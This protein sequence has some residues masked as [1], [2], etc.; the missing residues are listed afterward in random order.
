M[1]TIRKA[2]ALLT[3]LAIAGTIACFQGFLNLRDASRLAAG[4][5]PGAYDLIRILL[6]FEV[7]VVFLT[8]SFNFGFF[9][10]KKI[11]G[12]QDA[13][14]F[15]SGSSEYL[16]LQQAVGA[17]FIFVV[18]GY[19]VFGPGEFSLGAVTALSTAA[20]GLYRVLKSKLD[21]SYQKPKLSLTKR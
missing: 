12:D 20:W 14:S 7:V 13:E 18:R 15:R 3:I 6:F 5:D 1:K 21:G 16:I 9:I 11:V 8:A 10:I 2:A 19:F 4:P 17:T